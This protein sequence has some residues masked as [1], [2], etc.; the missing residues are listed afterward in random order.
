MCYP[1]SNKRRCPNVEKEIY[2]KLRKSPWS[3]TVRGR[4]AFPMICVLSDNYKFSFTPEMT[5]QD[6]HSL[7]KTGHL[8]ICPATKQL[9]LHTYRINTHLTNVQSK[10]AGGGKTTLPVW[11]EAWGT[12]HCNYHS[13]NRLRSQWTI[14][15]TLS[16]WRPQLY[17]RK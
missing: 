5:D 16:C 3:S 13:N 8:A 2:R 14:L 15:N 10:H 11:V 1:L 12:N 7:D 4:L 17:H 9:S 6:E